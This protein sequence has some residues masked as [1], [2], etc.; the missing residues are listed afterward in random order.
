MCIFCFFLVQIILIVNLC[1]TI[2]LSILLIVG[3][4][5]V[6]SLN[7]FIYTRVVEHFEQFLAKFLP[8]DAMGRARRYAHNRAARFGHR[9]LDQLLHRH[10]QRY[11]QRNLV[12]DSGT[13]LVW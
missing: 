10:A 6:R 13:D 12:A 7:L 2:I 9:D 11:F 1:V 3:T 4:I 5:K 8:D